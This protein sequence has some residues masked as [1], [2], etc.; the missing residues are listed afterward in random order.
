MTELIAF[1]AVQGLGAGGLIVL[2]QAVI[3]DV[4]LAA[5]A[6][7]LPGPVRRGVRDRQ[8]RRAADRRLDRA[9]RLVAL[10]LLRQRADRS[11]RAG[12]DQRDAAGERAGQPARRS[13]TSGRRCWPAALSAI[14]LVTSLGGTSWAWGS[15]AGDRRRGARRRAARRVPVRRAP[16]TRADRAARAAAQPRVRGRRVAVADRRLRAVRRGHVPAA[17]LPDGRR[18]LA[19]RLRPAADTADRRAADDVDPLRAADHAPRALQDLPD[20]RHGADDRRAAAA[21]RDSTSAPAPSTPRC[22]CSCSVS[23]SARRCRCWC[24]RCRTRSTSRSSARRP[25]G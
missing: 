20:H 15:G 21:A 18:R 12:G 19:D 10:D 7:A 17:V 24:W 2:V 4:V 13:T 6:R 25:P 5:R 3:G 11:R 16:R 1:R 22:T 9:A 14:V 23:G 8:R